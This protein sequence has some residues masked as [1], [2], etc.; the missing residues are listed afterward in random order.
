LSL[1][2]PGQVFIVIIEHAEEF[3][4]DDSAR[5]QPR[6]GGAGSLDVQAPNTRPAPE[7]IEDPRQI[8]GPI[9]RKERKNETT[10]PI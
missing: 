9:H 5:G 7:L 1:D 2:P 3:R 10:L 4:V 6:A 8:T